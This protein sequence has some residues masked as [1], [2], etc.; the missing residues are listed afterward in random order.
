MLEFLYLGL[1]AVLWD[2]YMPP[3]HVHILLHGFM[4]CLFGDMQQIVQMN[5]PPAPSQ[6][7]ILKEGELTSQQGRI[8]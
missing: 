2:L 4:G 1:H 6:G 7:I 8:V 3:K 5:F